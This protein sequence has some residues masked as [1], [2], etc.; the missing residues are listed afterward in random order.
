[1][2]LLAAALLTLLPATAGAV[3]NQR[4]PINEAPPIR[5]ADP[6]STANC[7]RTSGHHAYRGDGPLRPQKLTELPPANAYVAVWRRDANGCETPVVVRYNLG[8]R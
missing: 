3:S 5:G 1:M 6:S 8:G 7:P 4:A 2:R